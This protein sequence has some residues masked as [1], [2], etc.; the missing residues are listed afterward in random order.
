M[1]ASKIRLSRGYDLLVATETT[2]AVTVH[3]DFTCCRLVHISILVKKCIIIILVV[4]LYRNNLIMIVLIVAT[5][6]GCDNCNI[7]LE[8]Y[9]SNN[10]SGNICRKWHCKLDVKGHCIKSLASAT[11]AC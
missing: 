5:N 6:T 9:I 2:F 7:S 3:S 10:G 4:P 8:T 11:D 1:L